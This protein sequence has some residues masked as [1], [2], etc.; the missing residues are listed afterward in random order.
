[1][2]VASEV[3]N[4]AAFYARRANRTDLVCV[5]VSDPNAL[6]QLKEGDFVVDARGRRYFSNEVL[7]NGL[8]NSS[9]TTFQTW[10][11]PTVSA[12]VYQLD[13]KS[14]ETVIETARR[15]P[16]LASNIQLLNGT[17]MISN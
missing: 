16:P 2:Q 3:P 6:K 9:S 8:S 4:L 5:S 12:S 13:Q 7:L 11:G 17:H 10:L 1:A 15:L 14:L